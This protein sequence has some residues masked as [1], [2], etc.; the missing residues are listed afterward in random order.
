MKLNLISMPSGT[1]VQVNFCEVQDRQDCHNIRNSPRPVS[2]ALALANKR[3][4]VESGMHPAPA[5]AVALE[6]L[7]IEEA[8]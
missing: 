6:G 3:L 2:T 7:K 5:P 1:P 8:V 4:G